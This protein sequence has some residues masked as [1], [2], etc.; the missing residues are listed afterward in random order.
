M[1]FVIGVVLSLGFLLFGLLILGAGF[2]TLSAKGMT[3]DAIAALVIGGLLSVVGI[4]IFF[5][6]LGARKKRKA[7]KKANYDEAGATIVGMSMVSDSFDDGDWS[8]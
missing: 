3:E 5:V 1:R 6:A 4:I 8:D 7:G 2:D